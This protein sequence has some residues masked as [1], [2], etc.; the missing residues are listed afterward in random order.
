MAGQL[1]GWDKLPALSQN[2][3]PWPEIRRLFAETMG[4]RRK[5]EEFG[6]IFEVETR[7]F[8]KKPLENPTRW[9]EHT[10]RFASAIVLKVTYGYSIP[11]QFYALCRPGFRELGGKLKVNVYR[12][13]LQR[14]PDRPYEWTKHHMLDGSDSVAVIACFVL[15]M[16]LQILEQAKAQEELDAVLGAGVLPTLAERD[17]L[18]YF[19][20]AEVL[21]RYTCGSAGFPHVTDQDDVH[22]GYIIPKGTILITNTWASLNDPNIYPEPE[23]FSPDRFLVSPSLDTTQQDPRDFLFGF[24][25]RVC[26]GIHCADASIWLA[27][28]L[29]RYTDGAISHPAPFKTN[30]APRAI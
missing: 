2:S 21:R 1:V 22:D 8:L 4:S 16:N 14:M 30:I 17:R 20:A 11:F 15:A 12:R 6:D 9:V 3:H 7:A 10:K 29:V 28:P 18:P 25:R 5:V 24:G 13:S 27:P 19:N 23:I 26:P